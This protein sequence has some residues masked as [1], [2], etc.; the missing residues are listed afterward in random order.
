MKTV[1]MFE[2]FDYRASRAITVRFEPGV[3]YLRVLE[4]AAKQIER[5]GAGRIVVASSSLLTDAAGDTLTVD[6]RNAFKRRR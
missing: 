5:A 1:E 3:I 4:T 2:R 6:A